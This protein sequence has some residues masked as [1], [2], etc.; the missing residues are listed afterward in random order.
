M[1]FRHIAIEGVIGAG[2]TTL[3]T[4]LA[5]KLGGGAVL[6]SFSGNPFL[7]QF[8]ADPQ[9]YAFPLE[10]S[11]LAERFQQLKA[12]LQS[13]DLFGRP[14]ISDYVLQKSV[15]FA[16]VT[17]T[18]AELDLFQT[19]Y[20]LLNPQLPSPDLL[21]YL[22]TPLPKL[23]SQI[24]HRGRDY[25]QAISDDYLLNLGAAYERF[26]SEASFPVL[27]VDMKAADFLAHP[28]QLTAITSALETFPWKG[29]RIL[30]IV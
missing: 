12:V 22:N 9:R 21:I 28:E 15:L 16:H 18:G 23:R 3:V 10:V 26:L 30:E 5:Q 8:Y 20:R 19:L 2:K 17:L 7:P 6:E 29:R 24:A 27:V 14:V 11:F 13:A 25:E 1:P 4:L